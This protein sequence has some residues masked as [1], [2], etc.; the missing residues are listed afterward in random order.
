MSHARPLPD[1]A[2]APYPPHPAPQAATPPAPPPH[3]AATDVEAAPATAADGQTARWLAAG[4]A[5]GV[6]SAAIVAAA[7]YVG[8]K[9]KRG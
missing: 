5:I 9:D 8:R 1:A 4:A 3:G 6:G 2:T 7:M